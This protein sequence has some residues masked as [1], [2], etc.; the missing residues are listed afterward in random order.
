[1][2]RSLKC[3][4]LSRF[5]TITSYVFLISPT[6]ATCLAHLILLDFIVLN[7]FWRGVGILRLFVVSSLQPPTASSPFPSATLVVA[8]CNFTIWPE[9][10]RKAAKG[11]SRDECLSQ[12]SLWMRLVSFIHLRV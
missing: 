4:F 9:V 2:L 11:L 10:L 5:H 7:D 1:M 6:S 3:I 12:P 8:K